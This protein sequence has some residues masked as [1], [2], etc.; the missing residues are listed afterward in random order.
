MAI[1]VA[2]CTLS[3]RPGFMGRI[4]IPS[5]RPAWMIPIPLD[6]SSTPTNLTSSCFVHCALIVLYCCGTSI[7]P[8]YTSTTNSRTGAG[9]KANVIT[10]V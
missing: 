6:F 1:L 10:T 8:R 3:S 9:V 4:G 5:V 7:L 2:R